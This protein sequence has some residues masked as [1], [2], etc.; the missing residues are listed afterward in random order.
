MVQQQVQ[1]LLTRPMRDVTS[2][3]TIYNP[4]RDAFLL[5][6]PMRDVTSR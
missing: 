5:T 3:G 2:W 6:R 1:F 4:G